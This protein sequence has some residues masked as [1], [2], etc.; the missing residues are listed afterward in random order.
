MKY[1]GIA[2]VFVPILALGCGAPSEEL[3]AVADAAS[4]AAVEVVSFESRD[5]SDTDIVEYGGA[6]IAYVAHLTERARALGR[7]ELGRMAAAELI[8]RN[9]TEFHELMGVV[10]LPGS[11]VHLKMYRNFT[12][13]SIEDIYRSESYLYPVAF[14]IRFSYDL[15]GTPPRSADLPNAAALAQKD[16]EFSLLGR[17]SLVRRYRADGD[18][19]YTGNLPALPPRPNFYHRGQLLEE[20]N[21]AQP[22]RL[23][24]GGPS[25]SGPGLGG[26]LRIIAPPLSNLPPVGGGSF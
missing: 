6:E 1:V 25:F 14:E 5:S 10:F 13:F 20:P 24:P 19:N 15:L 22:N 9:S 3:A 7:R 4:E 17:F 12:D 2:V 16:L 26:Q 23:P 21:A 11:G 18:G 8:Y